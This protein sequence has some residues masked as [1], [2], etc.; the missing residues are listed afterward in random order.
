MKKEKLT[1]EAFKKKTFSEG[2]LDWIREAV[3]DGARSYGLAAILEFKN[4]DLF[5]SVD[6]QQSVLR[7]QVVTPKYSWNVLNNGSSVQVTQA[8][9]F[10]TEVDCF[11][12]MVPYWNFFIFQQNIAGVMQGEHVTH[13]LIA[14]V[15]PPGF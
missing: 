4:S 10:S 6:D 9:R 8:H 11:F 5:P 13:S 3:R 2:N 14:D 1:T 7:Q 12:S 15:S